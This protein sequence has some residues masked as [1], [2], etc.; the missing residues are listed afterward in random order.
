MK[1]TPKKAL[2]AVFLLATILIASWFLSKPSGSADDRALIEAARA[3]DAA[4]TTRLLTAGANVN[5]KLVTPLWNQ[6]KDGEPAAEE[7]ATP[8][9]FAVEGGFQPVVGELLA[10]GASIDAQNQFGNTPL[11]LA[12]GRLDS[13]LVSLLL[14]HGANASITNKFGKSCVDFAT[15]RNVRPE[16]RT[17]IK[18]LQDAIKQKPPIKS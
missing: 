5:V 17:L 16:D 4:A 11:M 18:T 15:K 14:E 2:P 3:G 12:A 10:K 7:G 6:L 1:I 9:H 8:L 13:K